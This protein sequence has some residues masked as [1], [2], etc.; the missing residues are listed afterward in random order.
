MVKGLS[1]DD[2]D[3]EVGSPD[4]MTCFALNLRLRIGREESKGADDF[5]LLVCTPTWL[6]QSVAEPMWGRH[7]LIVPKYDLTSIRNKV[8]DFVSSVS[9]ES[10][11][12]LALKLSRVF[13]WEYEDYQA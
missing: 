12:E 8:D 4:D 6:E 1:S 5:S 10:W 2:F 9:G 7:L 3:L 13:A 11:S